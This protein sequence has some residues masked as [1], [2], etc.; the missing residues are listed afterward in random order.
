MDDPDFEGDRQQ[1]IIAAVLKVVGIALAI[2][3]AIGVVTWV[4]VKQLNLGS[5]SSSSLNSDPLTPI[6][7][8]LPTTAL[9]SPVVP[10]SS[11]TSTPTPS[12]PLGGAVPANPTPTPGSTALFLSAS[13]VFVNSMERINLTGKWPGRDAISLMVQQFQGGKWVDFGVQAQLEVGTFATYVETSHD[14]DQRF[15]VFDPSTSTASNAVTVTVS[16]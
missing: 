10:S 6:T 11:P 14:G 9:P 7:T 2:G 1:Q 13:P 5:V 4:V 8:P 3:L 15:R 12:D 16:N